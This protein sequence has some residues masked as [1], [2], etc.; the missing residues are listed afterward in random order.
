[1]VIQDAVGPTFMIERVNIVVMGEYMIKIMNRMLV[2]VQKV[3]TR[4]LISAV[5]E[6]LKKMKMGKRSVARIKLMTLMM[7]SVVKEL[8]ITTQASVVVKHPTMKRNR[9]VA[10]EL[11][12]TLKQKSVVK[13]KLYPV[14]KAHV[15]CG[16]NV[17]KHLIT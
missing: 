12:T 5:K 4:T 14:M 6:I 9:A 8:F 2:V 11:S 13:G 1:M 3:T 17:I 16:N 10:N 7:K 15:K